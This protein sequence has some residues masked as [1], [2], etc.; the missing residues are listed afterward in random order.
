MPV[1]PGH[2]SDILTQLY[3][4]TKKYRAILRPILRK[5]A[6]EYPNPYLKKLFFSLDK[7]IIA[8]APMV[9]CDS[10]LLD[11]GEKSDKVDLAA[12]GLHMLAISTHDDVVDERPPDRIGLA[13]LVYAGNIATNDGSRMLLKKGKKKASDALLEFINLNHFYQQHVVETLWQKRPESFVEYKDGI[14][15]I[16]IFVAIGLVYGLALLGRMD[17][18]KRVIEYANSYGVALQLVDDL[19]EIEEDR[20]NG[21]WSFPLSEGEPYGESF[22]QLFGHIATA[23][24]VIPPEWKQLRRL[25]DNLEQFAQGIRQ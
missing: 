6:R 13:A 16:C 7:R 15:H 12:L 20:M 1:Q 17:L 24:E 14:N 23:K 5:L 22:K 4:D 21:Y 3:G 19:R 8:I 9:F 25:V 11:L 18:K 2:S 10:L